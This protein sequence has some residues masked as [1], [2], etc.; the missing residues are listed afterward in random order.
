[1]IAI[2]IYLIVTGISGIITSN[3]SN[4]SGLANG[5]STIVLYGVIIFVAFAFMAGAVSSNHDVTPYRILSSAGRNALSDILITLARIVGFLIRSIGRGIR[6]FFLVAIPWF[7]RNIT[8]RIY[9]FFDTVAL[10]R[11]TGWLHQPLAV[12]LTTICVI[13]II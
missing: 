12:L 7:H 13:L 10:R 4:L 11:I 5:V 8:R 1:M 6:L 3:T 2:I 9:H